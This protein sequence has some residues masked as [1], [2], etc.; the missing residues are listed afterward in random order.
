MPEFRRSRALI[1]GSALALFVAAFSVHYTVERGDTLGQI[2]RDHGVSLSDLVGANNISNPDRIYPGQMLV[3]PGQGGRTEVTHLVT[4]GETL[5]RIAAKYGSSVSGIVSANA[6]SNP[7]IIRIGQELLIPST[8]G[9]S[10]GSGSGEGSDIS[11]RSGQYHV[12][13][14]GESVK[15]IAA[16]YSGVSAD[17]ITKANGIINGRIYAGAALYLSGPGHVASGSAGSIS[18]TVRSGDRL[19]DIAQSHSVSLRTLVSEN[20][21]SNPNLIR[22]G[23]TLAIPSGTTWVCPVQGSRFMNDWGFPR[24]GGVRYHEGNDLFVSRGTPVK[25]PVGG[26]VEFTTGPIGGLQFRLMGNDGVVYIGTHM[27]KFGDDGTVRPGDII[28]YVGNSGNAVGTSPHLH[29]GM[30]YKGTVVNPYPTLVKH[31]C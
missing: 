16:Q 20:N 11:D 3:I 7:N 29:F 15:Q 22:S 9:R 1:I 24:G 27:D 30:Y 23:Q 21:I 5:D 26:T 13:K 28:G 2:A 10:G 14:R 6:I 18:Y 25:A 12:V 31:G 4:R 17:D 19:G 8:S